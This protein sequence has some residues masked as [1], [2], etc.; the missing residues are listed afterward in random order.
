MRGE[1]RRCCMPKVMPAHFREIRLGANPLKMP[2]KRRDIGRCPELVGEHHAPL[3]LPAPAGRE[4]LFLL[5][6]PMTGEGELLL[7]YNDHLF[8]DNAG[9]YFVTVTSCR[10]GRGTGDTNH[11]HFGVSGQ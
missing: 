7:F 2:T 9:E 1:Q 5:T 6:Y 4:S 10:P 3:R 8:G 11:C